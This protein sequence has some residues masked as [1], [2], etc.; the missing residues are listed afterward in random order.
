[1]ARIYYGNRARFEEN[2][3]AVDA[4]AEL[5]DDYWALFEFDV[6][7]GNIDCLVIRPATDATPASTPSVLILTE[8]KHVAGRL[9]GLE[10][11]RWTIERHGVTTTYLPS[12]AADDNPWQ[13][14]IRVLNAFRAWMTNNQRV[15]F[16]PG[17]T[18]D[19]T[20]IKVWP[21]LLVIRTDADEPHGLPY[22]PTN[23]FGSFC[24]SI[25]DWIRNISSWTPRVGIQLTVDDVRR[26]VTA[27]QLTEWTRPAGQAGDAAP[28]ATLAGTAS[29]L[30]GFAT[31]PI[32][33]DVPAQSAAGEPAPIEPLMG[34]LEWLDGLIAWASE[35]ERRVQALEARARP[36]RTT[37]AMG[38]HANGAG[39]PLT[40]AESEAM[41]ETT[42]EIARLG[43]SRAFP[44]VIRGMSDRLGYNLKDAGYGGFGTA[45]NMF[46]RAVRDGIIK[47]GPLSGPSPTIY[48]AGESVP[49]ENG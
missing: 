43:L 37:M 36:S 42:R 35:I 48:L 38:G 25:D 40:D 47:Y 17:V 23:R 6:P 30:P 1:M 24:F 5:S 18:H 34:G 20:D 31:E 29:V 19:Y 7:G 33:A 10:N 14:A 4:I 26:L 32:A 44:N 15:F 46:D 16:E 21:T 28:D 9:V 3:D 8:I 11:G 39:R 12:N 41:V 45:T 22:G 13:Q 2:A 49:D 27:L